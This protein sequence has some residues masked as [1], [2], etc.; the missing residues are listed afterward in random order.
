MRRQVSLMSM[1]VLEGWQFR[2]AKE[3]PI[4]DSVKVALGLTLAL[5]L[6]LSLALPPTITLTLTLTLTKV[7]LGGFG[8]QVFFKALKDRVMGGQGNIAG[9]L[10][11]EREETLHQSRRLTAAKA[12]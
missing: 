7:A 4:F 3:L 10:E 12:A 6:T 11:A 8:A 9:Q 1:M 5:T 2:L